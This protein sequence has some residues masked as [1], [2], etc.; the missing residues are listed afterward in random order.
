MMHTITGHRNR[1]LRI[2]ITPKRTNTR[3]PQT[4]SQNEFD[5]GDKVDGI[6]LNFS[7]ESVSLGN[8][9]KLNIGNGQRER[10][11]KIRTT[12]TRTTTRPMIIKRGMTFCD[13]NDVSGEDK[14]NYR[15]IML[16]RI[17]H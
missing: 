4:L 11:H 1:N 6:Q 14:H 17:I 5:W 15:T 3:E 12:T 9:L 2:Y 13:D 8:Y 10:E 7:N 16:V